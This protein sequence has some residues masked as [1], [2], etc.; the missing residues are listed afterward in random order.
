MGTTLSNHGVYMCWFALVSIRISETRVK[1]LCGNLDD[2]PLSVGLKRDGVVNIG[3]G[4]MRNKLELNLW[5]SSD[6]SDRAF[7]LTQHEL[8][9]VHNFV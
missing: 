6:S 1:I 4:F 3:G 8:F 9:D 7:L 2:V 5:I